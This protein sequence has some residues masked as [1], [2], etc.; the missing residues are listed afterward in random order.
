MRRTKRQRII[1]RLPVPEQ[2]ALSAKLIDALGHIG[3][4]LDRAQMNR[5]TLLGEELLSWNQ[6]TNL[7]AITDPEAVAL[8]HFLDSLVAVPL[9]RARIGD[10]PAHLIDV[11]TGAG[12][13]GLPLAVALPELDVTLIEATGK[14]VEFLTHVIGRMGLASARAIHG[15]AEELG[16]D[17]ELRA[18]ATVAVA[19]AVARVGVLCELTLPFLALG[20]WT[21]LWKTAA[22]VDAEVAEAGF[23]LESLGGSIEAI[24]DVAIPGLLDGRVCVVIRKSTSTPDLYPRRPG[25]PQRRPLGARSAK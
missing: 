14:K 23:A 19:R 8:K 25:V 9:L 6:R 7:T 21:C 5:L 3:V 12:F 13:P 18:T 24:V 22:T 17:P 2:F 11:G 4:A 20:G 1:G 16:H 10:Q 15:R